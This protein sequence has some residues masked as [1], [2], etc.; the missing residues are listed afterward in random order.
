M[1]DYRALMRDFRAD[2]SPGPRRLAAL[3]AGLDRPRTRVRWVLAAGVALAAAALFLLRPGPGPAEAIPLS[4]PTGLGSLV[5]VTPEGEGSAV[6]TARGY[7]VAWRHGRLEVEVVPDRGAELTV[8]T[9]EATISVVGT[10]FSVDRNALGTTVAVRHGTVLVDCA[11][12]GAAHLHAGEDRVCL[13]RTAAGALGRI[14]AL[15]DAGTDPGQVLAEAESAASRPDATG[16]VANEIG[17]VRVSALLLLDRRDDAETT[18]LDVLARAPGARDAELHR[19]VARLAVARGDCAVVLH[20]LDALD[21]LGALGDDAALRG[22]CPT[23][24]P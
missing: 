8:T 22:S 16:S 7:A 9:D 13:P 11:L 2:T 17:A 19:V 6:A 4:T 5:H 14:R 18:A 24:A 21:T 15:Q 3:R 12:G 10:G 20:H 1:A 23:E